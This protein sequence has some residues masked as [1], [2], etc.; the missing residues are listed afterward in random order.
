MPVGWF[1]APYKRRARRYLPGRYCAMD[2]A[3]VAIQADGGAWGE[4][5][6]DGSLAIVKVRA[7]DSL[8][9]KISSY[10]DVPISRIDHPATYWT[11]TRQKLSGRGG[12]I[13]PLPGIWAI[14]LDLETVNRA[15]LNDVAWGEIQREAELLARRAEREGYVKIPRNEK[16]NFLLN[17]LGQWGY[18]FDRVSTGTFPTTGVIDAF[19]RANTGPPPSADW[20]TIYNGHKVASNQCIGNATSDANLSGWDTNT[21]GPASEGYITIPT[22]GDTSATVGIFLRLTTLNLSTF[23]GYNVECQSNGVTNAVAIYRID[24]GATTQ[25]GATI[26]QA[27]SSGDALGGEGAGSNLRAYRKP[28][29]GSWAQLG[30]NRTDATYGSAGYIGL[31]SFGTANIL[32]DFGGGTTLGP[33]ASLILPRYRGGFQGLIVR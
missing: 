9:A 16:A 1:V 10:T 24:N 11:T 30:T 4:A 17:L 2:D 13:V 27:Y 5:E 21:F 3:S 6:I 26:T 15:V 14:C 22:D 32:D 33:A 8:L 20:T 19:N 31:W 18:G 25:L 12:E 28:S 23:D 7:R 29:G